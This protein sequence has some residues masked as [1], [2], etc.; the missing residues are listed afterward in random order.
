MPELLPTN[1]LRSAVDS[2]GVELGV[3]DN[4]YSPTLVEFYG[5]SG[6]DFVQ[7]GFGMAE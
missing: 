4:I 5:D 3:L 1:G 6:V 2:G 7:L